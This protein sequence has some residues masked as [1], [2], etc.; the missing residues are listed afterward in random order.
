MYR[1]Q[2][3]KNVFVNTIKG[4]VEKLWVTEAKAKQL[5]LDGHTFTELMQAKW[6]DGKLEIPELI[7]YDRDFTAIP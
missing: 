4:V 1:I 7:G 2:S 5:L 3:E 6:K